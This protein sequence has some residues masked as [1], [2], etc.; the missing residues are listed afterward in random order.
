[1]TDLLVLQAGRDALML[2]LFIAGPILLVGLV[3]GLLISVFQ[4]ATQ[5]NEMTLAYIPKIVA[6][7][8]TVALLGPWMIGTM[9]SYTSGLLERLPELIK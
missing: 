1:M 2:V 3:V 4:A 6:I 7:F 8:A 9:V 5:V